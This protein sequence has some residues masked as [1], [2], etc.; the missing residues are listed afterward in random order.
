MIEYF[1]V[2][3][4]WYVKIVQNVNNADFDL[5]L[6]FSIVHFLFPK[7]KKKN[8]MPGCV[9]VYNET[10]T[11][12]FPNNVSTNRIETMTNN[13]DVRAFKS[14]VSVCL[15]VLLL[16]G[17]LLLHLLRSFCVFLAHS[18]VYTWRNTHTTHTHARNQK[19]VCVFS[20]LEIVSLLEIITVLCFYQ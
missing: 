8:Y 19:N 12:F 11:S 18:P 1:C 15:L 14:Q 16:V 5:N 9:H 20:H 3:N 7:I 4:S 17:S 13:F 6:W 10:V 2:F